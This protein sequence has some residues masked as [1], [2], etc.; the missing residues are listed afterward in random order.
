VL[1]EL[2]HRGVHDTF[3]VCCDCDD[4]EVLLRMAA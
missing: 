4:D 2:R 3:I 1:G